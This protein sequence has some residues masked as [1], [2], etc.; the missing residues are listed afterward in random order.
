MLDGLK[1]RQFG[2][3]L[4]RVRVLLSPSPTGDYIFFWM[5]WHF[6]RQILFHSIK[7]NYKIGE[8]TF[9]TAE[10]K[11]IMNEGFLNKSKFSVLQKWLI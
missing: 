3:E 8:R 7:K 10:K 5:R 6:R 4:I 2:G 1:S 9:L 11:D